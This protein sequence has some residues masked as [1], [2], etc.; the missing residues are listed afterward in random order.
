M[1]TSNQHRLVQEV[2]LLNRPLNA[3]EEIMKIKL[4]PKHLPPH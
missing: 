3:T 4:I 2:V 1:E